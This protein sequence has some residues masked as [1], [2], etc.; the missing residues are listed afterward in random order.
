MDTPGWDDVY[1]DNVEAFQR[2]LQ[3]LNRQNL[4]SVRAILWAV[5]PSQIR[6]DSSILRQADFINQFA[7][8][9]IW[10]NVIIICKS[11]L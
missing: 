10:D 4:T 2:L 11:L 6:L 1:N 5:H 8:E 7:P 3:F 9:V